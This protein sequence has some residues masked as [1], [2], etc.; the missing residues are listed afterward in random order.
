MNI[1]SPYK[2]IE[3]DDGSIYYTII[4]E[5]LLEQTNTILIFLHHGLGSIAQWKDFPQNI[6]AECKL[7]ALVYERFGHANSSGYPH[8]RDK[9]F[10]HKEA[11]EY[12]PEILN[13]MGLL[14]KKIILVG[15]SDGATISL[16][17]SGDNQ[18]NIKGCVSI[19]SHVI[20]EK[21]TKEGLEKTIEIFE[22]LLYKALKKFHKEKTKKLFYEW[23]QIWLSHDFSDWNIIDFLRKI[24]FSVLAIQG[25]KDNYATTEQ[26][27]VIKSEC[28]NSTTHLIPKCGHEPHHEQTRDTHRLIVNY[29]LKQK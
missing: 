22:Q 24:P 20:I 16:I 9:N 7:P 13:K 17:A 21:E 26:L 1:L 14:S 18:L 23:T 11:L 15:H 10:L 8:V 25:D 5:E 19:A 2:Y 29:I 6:S 12:L 28:K 4:N 3:I 27:N